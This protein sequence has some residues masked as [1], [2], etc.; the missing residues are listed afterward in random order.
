[1]NDRFRIILAALLV[2]VGLLCVVHAFVSWQQANDA[3]PPVPAIMPPPEEDPEDT[4]ADDVNTD[5][6]P[7]AESDENDVAGAPVVAPAPKPPSDDPAQG[8]TDKAREGALILWLVA[9]LPMVFVV[10]VAALLVRRW[11]RP[12]PMVRTGPSDTTDLWV[13]AGKRLK[14]P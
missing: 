5:E 14:I 4:G 6:A 8:P 9:A 3:V 12:K 11:A 13:E 10:F 1:M 2:I 7:S